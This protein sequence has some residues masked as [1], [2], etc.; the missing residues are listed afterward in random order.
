MNCKIVVPL[1]VILLCNDPCLGS[2]AEEP[3]VVSSF[4]EYRQHVLSKVF[5][6][7]SKEEMAKEEEDKKPKIVTFLDNYGVG[8]DSYLSN[9]YDACVYHLEAA[10]RGYQEYYETVARCR[11]G[12]EAERNNRKPF[13]PDNPEH[14]H[15]FEGVIS[16]T[17][18]L[19]RCLTQRLTNLPKY[20]SMD[21]WHKN[22]FETRAPYE[23]L[24]ICYYRQGEVAK[25]IQA[26]YTVLV[27]R[28]DDHLSAT[29]M[30]FY[31]TESEYD[32]SLLRDLEEKRFVS[33]YVEGI[34]AYDKEDDW[35][36]AIN[37]LETSL[38]LYLDEEEQC[39]AFCENGFDQGWFPDFISSTASEGIAPLK[40]KSSI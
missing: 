38:Q 9:D 37:L 18:C 32:V 35:T 8:I 28:P 36:K 7:K 29:N 3:S 5:Q 13:F 14:S 30:K 2:A 6:L 21:E 19:K 20:F 26:T 34:M 39:R 17:I 24:Q 27:V 15:F 23:Y 4:A 16:K 33:R 12:C 11:V 31:E 22:Q 40:I 1:L 25:A 10:V